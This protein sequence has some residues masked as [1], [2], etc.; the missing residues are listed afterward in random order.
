M[1]GA[2]KNPC[3]QPAGFV[4]PVVDPARCEGKA[5]CVAA[6]PLDVFEIVRIASDTFDT[7]PRFA[8]FK[9]WVHGM[10]TAATPRADACEACG[11]CVA[12]CPE[13][14]IRLQRSDRAGADG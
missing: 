1:D 13:K 2:T 5:A 9:V 11:L 8:K 7:L 14:A 3:R 6:C 4:R 12:A 10:K